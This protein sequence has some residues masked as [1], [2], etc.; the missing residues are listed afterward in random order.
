MLLRGRGL[1][2]LRIRGGA[3]VPRAALNSMAKGGKKA[4][5]AADGAAKKTQGASTAQQRQE[6]GQKGHAGE[7]AGAGNAALGMQHWSGYL[8]ASMGPKSAGWAAQRRQC[9]LPAPA[10]AWRAAP[11]F[12][13]PQTPLAALPASAWLPVHR[14]HVQQT[15]STPASVAPAQVLALDVDHT[16]PS[17]LLFLDKERYLFNAGE[18]IQRLFR[19]HRKKITEVRSPYRSC[20]GPAVSERAGSPRRHVSVVPPRLAPPVAPTQIDAYF[21]TRIST[22]TLGGLPG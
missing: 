16:S 14:H 11:H 8:Q 4:A 12:R 10:G 19:E 3:V 15:T 21:V 18:G 9:G 22:A 7:N 1:V 17:L 13:S 5:E 6:R 2:Q 20:R